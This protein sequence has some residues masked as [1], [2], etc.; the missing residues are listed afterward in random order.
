VEL[1]RHHKRVARVEDDRATEA[2]QLSWSVRDIFDALV[3][4][5]V[6]PIQDIPSQ[7]RSAKDVLMVFGLVLERLWDEHASGIGSQV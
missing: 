5:N 1:E 7:P 4:L 6:L 2:E 3:N